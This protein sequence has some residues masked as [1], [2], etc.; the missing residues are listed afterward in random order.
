MMA[1]PKFKLLLLVLLLGANTIIAQDKTSEVD[2]LFS[3]ITQ[4]SPG[5][6]CAVSHHG[7]V[8][9]NKA[10]GSS[11]LER[12][13]LNTTESVFDIGS[14]QKQFIAAAVLI[15]AEEGK[16]AL[17]DDIRKYIPEM[18]EFDHTITVDH[19]LTHTSG[20]RDWTAL[21]QMENGD[22]DPLKLIF[23]QRGL[24]HVPGE[25]FL[26]SNSGYALA[27][28]IVARVSGMS[29]G[30]F[31]QLKLFGPLEMKST[32]FYNDLH[33][34]IPNRALAYEKED[35]QW[36]MSMR[37]GN[38][39]G[40]GGI[41]STASDL[42][43]WNDALTNMKLGK[44]VTEKLQEHASLSNGRKLDYGRGLF[45]EENHGPLVWHSGSA[46]GYKSLLGRFMDHGVSIAIVCNSGAG[47][48][49]SS[50]G[51]RIFD[52]LVPVT[53]DKPVVPDGLPPAFAEGVDTSGFDIGGRQGL[54]FNES[55]GQPLNLVMEKGRLRIA[56]GPALVAMSKD[57][58]KRWGS[59][60]E[61][62]S[63]DAFEIHFVSRDAFEM[64]SMEGEVT[65]YRHAISYAPTSAEL[66][67]FEG[68]YESDEIGVVFKVSAVEDGLSIQLEHSPDKKIDFKPV[69]PD[70]FQWNRMMIRFHRDSN[71]K[72]ISFDYTNPVLRN[73]KFTR[74]PA[75]IQ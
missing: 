49:T 44:F 46:Y 57:H 19:L 41:F 1:F 11:D 71:G 2:K 65:R 47:Q 35:D 28:E 52:L 5:C 50:I 32:A 9:Y 26:Y 45:L 31:A 3:W 63:Q 27:R 13:V 30:E 4:N 33:V 14:I 42:L 67:S 43:I 56:Q 68:R 60:L 40:G 74:L 17:N 62:M 72:P 6:V 22:T 64:K 38:D 18:H 12:N 20:L 53:N 55:N 15:L 61:F 24:N 66:N 10:F 70:T 8:V 59:K 7:K 39:R 54:Y 29:F 34:V 23:R 73:V 51:K 21:V 37:M 25:E 16:L 36:K 58:F 69:D 75:S 48:N